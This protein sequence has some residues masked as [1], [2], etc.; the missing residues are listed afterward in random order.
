MD[1]VQGVPAPSGG[2]GWPA[3]ISF[4]QVL[5]EFV[6]PALLDRFVVNLG[7]NDG[8]RHDPAFPLLVERGYGG[9]FCE[10]A[11]NFKARLYANLKPF[12]ASGNVRVA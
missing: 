4:A 6:P 3:N 5:D 7:A 11:S 1:G 12:N 10:G 8:S 9:V 2:G